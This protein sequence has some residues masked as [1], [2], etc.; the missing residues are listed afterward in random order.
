MAQALN[1]QRWLDIQCVQGGADAFV[2]GTV[3]TDIVPEDGLI[4]KVTAVW[5]EIVTSMAG[6]AADAHLFWSLTRDTKTAVA[7]LSDPD[8]FLADTFVL[9]LTT[10]GAV[11]FSQVWRYPDQQ[12]IYLVEPTLYGQLDSSSTS[13]TLTAN[14]RVFYEEVRANE[15]DIL[16]ITT[17]S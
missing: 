14:F 1:I 8:C 15:V 6:L 17:N 13:L 11:A 12:G 16:R 3:A 7:T 10:S 9:A 2:Q 4:L 5:F